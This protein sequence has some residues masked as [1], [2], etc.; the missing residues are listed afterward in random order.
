VF[1]AIAGTP[2]EVVQV[3]DE[4]F[5]AGLAEAA[6]LPIEVGRLLASFGRAARE[7][8]LEVISSDFE[9]LTGRAPKSLRSV[10]EA[11]RVAPVA[12]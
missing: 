5:A 10:L 4:E 12:G 11:Q 7:A 8:Q 3:D 1:A 2:V 9:Q 6:G